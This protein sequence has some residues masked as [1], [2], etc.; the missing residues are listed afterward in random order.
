MATSKSWKVTIGVL[1]SCLLPSFLG[2]LGPATGFTIDPDHAEA[3]IFAALGIPAIGVANA[4]QKARRPKQ[5]SEASPKK[6]KPPDSK[7]I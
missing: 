2:A 7:K 5:D 4:A 1:V 3:L 6:T